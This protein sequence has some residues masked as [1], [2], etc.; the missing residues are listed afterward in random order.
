MTVEPVPQVMPYQSHSVPVSPFQP[1]LS[2]QLS[3]FVLIYS[4]RRASRSVSVTAI[5]A[6]V[7]TI[8]TMKKVQAR[9]SLFIIEFFT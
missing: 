1:V 2:V 5:A 4:A 3:P 6:V 7:H 8:A 9:K